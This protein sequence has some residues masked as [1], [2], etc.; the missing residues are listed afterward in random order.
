MADSAGVGGTRR[1]GRWRSRLLYAALAAALLP[2]LWSQLGPAVGWPAPARGEADA[3]FADA[4]ER[5][6]GRVGS[7]GFE[8]RAYGARPERLD[9]H[10]QKAKVDD[11]ALGR[12]MALAGDG[13]WGLDLRNTSIT[14]AG[15]AHLAHA[16]RLRKLAIGNLG[17]AF[18]GQM[19]DLTLTQIGDAGLAH[20][21]GLT[22]LQ[23]LDLG[24]T[25]VSG[26][27]LARLRGAKGLTRLAMPRTP[28]DDAGLATLA[29]SLPH[30]QILELDGTKI[31]DAGLAE[32]A[33]L[34]DLQ[35]L[36]L[37]G[38]PLTP[39]G[40]AHLRGLKKLRYLGLAGTGLLDDEV[41]P[42]EAALPDL[43]I[44]LGGGK[45]ISGRRRAM[46]VKPPEPAEHR[47]APQ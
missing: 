46:P 34:A 9:V 28:I 22:G 1:R 23:Q 10:L 3:R 8:F 32:V 4:V 16:A 11:E 7:Q 18:A 42:L 26:P 29:A 44:D 35:Y 38:C 39:E 27:G 25:Q 41:A 36:S 6:G 14:D 40:L 37:R 31:T 2:Y 20:L 47:P 45:P 24:E 30:L 17:T 43:E 21:E 15:L 13:P 33:G 19:P 5:L 12:L